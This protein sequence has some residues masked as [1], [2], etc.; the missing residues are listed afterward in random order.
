VAAEALGERGSRKD[1]VHM[2]T[3]DRKCRKE[4][5]PR[6]RKN[7]G[8][9]GPETLYKEDQKKAKQIYGFSPQSE[10]SDMD[11]SERSTGGG[12]RAVQQD[13][14]EGGPVKEVNL[15]ASAG[16]IPFCLRC[17]GHKY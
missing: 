9:S 13:E 5:K 3:H 1:N 10:V 17:A 2:P 4:K 11:L 8:S 16:S 6:L 7:K 12:S 15:K 14:K